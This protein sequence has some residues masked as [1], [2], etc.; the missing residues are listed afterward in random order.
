[1]PKVKKTIEEKIRFIINEFGDETFSSRG[2]MIYCNICEKLINS[3]RRYVMQQHVK[4]NK[5]QKLINSGGNVC[6]AS[7]GG[8]GSSEP[9]GTSN[10]SGLAE[11]SN[12][13]A[14]PERL[15]ESVPPARTISFAPNFSRDLC[16]AFIDANIPLWKLENPSLR[17]FLGKY[18]KKNIPDES[19]LRKNYVDKY[20]AQTI[21]TIREKTANKKLWVSMDETID[22]TG[23]QM[24][25]VIV[26][27]MEPGEQSHIYLLTC[28][29]LEATNSTT[30]AQ[31]FNSTLRSLWKE[32]VKYDDVLLFIT[33][34]AP[35]MK[36]AGKALQVL[37][38]KMTHVTCLAHALHRVAEEIRRLF[39]QVDRLIANG[40]K[41]FLKSPAR[42]QSFREKAPKLPLPPQPIVTRWGSWLTAVQY[43]ASH[44]NEFKDI[45]NT[46]DKDETAAVRIACETMEDRNVFCD[47][48]FIST[49]FGS[50]PLA[51]TKLET[52]NLPLTEA[53]NIF[54]TATSKLSNAPGENGLAIKS[55]CDKVILANTG[56][57]TL[58]K[59]RNVLDGSQEE[60]FSDNMTPFDISCFKYAPVTSVEV[61][62][63][64]SALKN[65]LSDKRLRL[66]E[67]NV[68][69]MIVASCNKLE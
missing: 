34:A 29:A 57:T 48:T 20:Y 15:D 42:C 39:P 21:E 62:R 32:E 28:E 41:I 68:R 33:D 7:F 31:L 61:E 16:K 38:P 9:V 23:R 6:N 45:V 22:A 40:K 53:L 18:T 56:L 3:Q 52:R 51:I 12:I 60:H 24:C 66:T 54:K 1:M 65:I 36:K 35:Y 19:T 11:R 44:F 58:N 49:H 10:T 8:S 63:S 2:N 5:H 47:L 30:I 59:I 46:F 14:P 4:S 67:V 50:L 27:T 69:K 55:K 37:F 17:N 64:F 26:G 13:G 43:Y 25:N